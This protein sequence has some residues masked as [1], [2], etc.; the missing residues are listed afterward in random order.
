MVKYECNICSRVF[1][2]RKQARRHVQDMHNI[3]SDKNSNDIGNRLS[4]AKYQSPV[5]GAITR[6]E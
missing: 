5:T 4:H 3:K 1:G 2:L 6:I